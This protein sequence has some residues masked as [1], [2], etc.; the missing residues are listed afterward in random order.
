M[1]KIVSTAPRDAEQHERAHR[2]ERF[3]ERARAAAAVNEEPARELARHVHDLP[4]PRPAQPF[5]SVPRRV[6]IAL[7]RQ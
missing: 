7:N 1:R 5:L 2:C 4:P 6:I 3:A